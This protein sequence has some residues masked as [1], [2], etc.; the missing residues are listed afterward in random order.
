M[1]PT[2]QAKNLL[3]F[4]RLFIVLSFEVGKMIQMISL[5]FRQNCK[6]QCRCPT[7]GWPDPKGNPESS[8]DQWMCNL[9]NSNLMTSYILQEHQRIQTNTTVSKVSDIGISVVVYEKIIFLVVFKN[10]GN[11]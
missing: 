10:L 7:T 4:C 11:V 8:T 5:G 9:N 1:L 6:I 2:F 3:N